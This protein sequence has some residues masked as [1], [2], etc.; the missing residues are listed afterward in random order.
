MEKVTSATIRRGLKRAT[1]AMAIYLDDDPDPQDSLT[2]LLTD[3]QHWCRERNV[4]FENQLRV[5]RSHFESE[6]K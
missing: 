5:A 4:D 2:D 1:A 3:L 6:A